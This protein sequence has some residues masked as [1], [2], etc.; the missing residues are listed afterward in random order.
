V[1]A[2]NRMDMLEEARIA[3][4]LQ[5]GA[6]AR[7]DLLGGTELLEMLTICG[8]RA[9]GIDGLVGTLEPGKRADMAAF[10]VRGAGCF[11]MPDP[12]DALI[13]TVR[14]GDADFVM[15]DGT[16]LMK[17]GRLTSPLAPETELLMSAAR[18][19]GNERL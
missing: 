13:H 11:P 3:S 4:F 14:G 16:V 8:A 5:R 15:V 10:A 7:A 12:A 17:N 18:R 1:V 9:L 19:I 2:N 6:G